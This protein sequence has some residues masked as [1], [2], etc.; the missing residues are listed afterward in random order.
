MFGKRNHK[1]I[2]CATEVT[3]KYLMHKHGLSVISKLDIPIPYKDMQKIADRIYVLKDVEDDYLHRLGLVFSAVT[4]IG[5]PKNY[6]YLIIRDRYFSKLPKRMKVFLILHE[7]GHA[8]H[9]IKMGYDTDRIINQTSKRVQDGIVSEDEFIAD[10]YA[11]RI[12][13]DKSVIDSLTFLIENTD[14]PLKSKKEA[15]LRIEKIL[16]HQYAEVVKNI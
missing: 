12:I 9:Y 3:T 1:T 7:M 13:G 16:N 11:A 14:L 4:C 10:A 8:K 5:D 6:E 2:H 15:K